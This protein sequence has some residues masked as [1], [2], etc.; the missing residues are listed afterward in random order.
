MHK[1]SMAVI[2]SR[3][4]CRAH[5]SES[6]FAH[7]LWRACTVAVLACVIGS[8]HATNYFGEPMYEMVGYGVV[9]QVELETSSL[10]IS[11]LRYQVLLDARIDIDGSFGAYSLL[12]PGSPVR[13]EYRT[14]AWGTT[15]EITKLETISQVPEDQMH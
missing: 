2:G 9:S 15:R 13:F 10:I 4:A 11:G 6:R 8:A 12:R 7:I 5:S 14:S 3:P 1:L